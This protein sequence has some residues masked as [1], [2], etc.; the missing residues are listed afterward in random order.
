MDRQHHPIRI[1]QNRFDN[2][3]LKKAM[4][5]LK[6]QY[7]DIILYKFINDLSNGEIAEILGKS[8]GSLRILQ[9]RALKALRKELEELGVTY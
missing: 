6:K 1:T 3:T 9:F 4:A 8:E 5:K 2:E 7:H